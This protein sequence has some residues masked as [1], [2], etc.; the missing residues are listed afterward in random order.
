VFSTTGTTDTNTVSVTGAATAAA[1]SLSA[2]SVVVDTNN[3]VAGQ[4]RAAMQF[5]VTTGDEIGN[6]ET[7]VVT[8]SVNE[9][10]SANIADASC[11]ITLDGTTVAA[12]KYTDVVSGVSGTDGILTIRGANGGFAAGEVVITCTGGFAA[13]DAGTNSIGTFVFSTTGNVDGNTLS[14]TGANTI[15]TTSLSAGSVT[16]TELTTGLFKPS[17]AMG[18]TTGDAIGTGDTLVVT[19]SVA[20]V[21]AG[22]LADAGCT[23]TVAGTA[24]NASK[25][26]SA[27]SGVSGTAGILTITGADGGFAAGATVITCTCNLAVNPAA[28][29]SIG[30]FVFSTTGTSDTNTISVVGANAIAATSSPTA[31][32]TSFASRFTSCVAGVPDVLTNSSGMNIADPM[33]ATTVTNALPAGI[34]VAQKA[35]MLTYLNCSTVAVSRG[36]CAQTVRALLQTGAW[37]SGNA[38]VQNIAL[39]SNTT[40]LASQTDF[41]T[42]LSGRLDALCCATC[43]SKPASALDLTGSDAPRTGVA[44]ASVIVAAAVGLFGLRH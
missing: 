37:D 28:G 25:F 5:K 43:L 9:V 14:V 21:F 26:T 17:L 11:T 44:L 19:T 7:L 27:L 32:P 4:P 1:S 35:L 42:V 40:A 34:R 36:V 41:N 33:L 13:N 20:A 31:A 38:A 6:T 10:W 2:A 16:S 18:I 24:V 22:D 30:T 3:L 12:N 39:L 15:A 29:S 23:I 8:T